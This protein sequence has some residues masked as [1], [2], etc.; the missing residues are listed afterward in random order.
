MKY[1]IKLDKTKLFNLKGLLPSLTCFGRVSS[2]NNKELEW[3]IDES[4]ISID[5][6][7]EHLKRLVSENVILD[8]SRVKRKEYI[9]PKRNT[10]KRFGSKTRGK[11][12]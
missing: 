1:I 11:R 9:P 6:A 10:R 8:F 4:I 3:Y 7:L 5:C 12:K 2:T